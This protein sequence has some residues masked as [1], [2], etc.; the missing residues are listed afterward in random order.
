[1][2]S[3][4]PDPQLSHHE[5]GPCFG[6]SDSWLPYASALS[7]ATCCP[8][9][10]HNALGHSLGNSVSGIFLSSPQSYFP[11]VL[12]HQLMWR[13]SVII[14]SARSQGSKSHWLDACWLE[15]GATCLQSNGKNW[16]STAHDAFSLI[17]R[18]DSEVMWKRVSRK[19]TGYPYFIIAQDLCNENN[20]L[21]YD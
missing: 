18:S 16:N 6:H 21:C 12:G 2:I 1:M 20:H 4:P 11:F 14:M 7:M 13:G 19:W 17:A 9:S 3:W 15:N 8:W 5:L 10:S